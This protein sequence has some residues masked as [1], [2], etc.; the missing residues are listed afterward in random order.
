MCRSFFLAL[1]L[2]L[3]TVGSAQRLAL[4]TLLND[5]MP[6]LVP[7]SSFEESERLYCLWTQQAAKFNANMRGWVSCTETTPDHFSTQNEPTC[8]AHPAKRTNGRTSPH[9][10]NAMVGIKTWGKGQTPTYWHEYV[11]IELPQPLKPGTRYI[12]E[13]WVQRANFSS[14]AS[15]NIGLLLADTLLHTRDRL[16]LYATPQVNLEEVLSKGGWHKVQGVFDATTP[17][18]WLHIGN[19]YGDEATLHEKQPEGERGAYYFIDDVNLRVAPL[20]TPLTPTPKPSIAPKPKQTLV[21]PAS[22]AQVDL[23]Q[24]EPVV[25]TQVRLDN[26]FFDVDK[27]E[28][29]PESRSELDKVVHLLTDYPYLRIAIEAHTD[30]QGTDDHNMKLSAARAK[31]VVDYLADHEVEDARLSSQGFGESRPLA[32]N[33]TESGRALNRRVEFRV[34]ER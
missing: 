33:G 34:V 13:Y 26:I 7:N 31:A 29:K 32:D 21:E 14:E 30:H 18:A 16:P 22:T 17:A 19:F 2:V 3:S 1:C 24:V 20:N 28:L 10:G 9:S 11:A 23:Y 8:W 4:R 27:A 5:T 12:A 15:N 6:N 25:G